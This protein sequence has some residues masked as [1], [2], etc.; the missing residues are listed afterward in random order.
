MPF[1][2]SAHE[3]YIDVICFDQESSLFLSL[4]VINHTFRFNI[5]SSLL[6]LLR[7]LTRLCEGTPLQPLRLD[8]FGSTLPRI[9]SQ[10]CHF[11]LFSEQENITRGKSRR[12]YERN[13]LPNRPT[14][15]TFSPN[16]PPT[17]PSPR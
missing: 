15:M 10:N 5:I 7:T 6:K 11:S 8:F 13:M 2:E 14:P 16:P 3:A 12:A 1:F 9:P 17:N 4:P